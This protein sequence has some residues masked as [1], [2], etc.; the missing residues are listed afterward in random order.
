MPRQLLQAP[1]WGR[2]CEVV[3][4]VDHAKCFRD[5]PF[6]PYCQLTNPTPPPTAVQTGNRLA[7]SSRI[8]ELPEGSLENPAIISDDDS[9]RQ[10]PIPASMGI[11]TRFQGT[12][13]P[14]TIAG[15]ARDNQ[16]VKDN[17]KQLIQGPVR[18][19]GSAPIS[20]QQQPPSYARRNNF[21]VAVQRIV[22]RYLIK[23]LDLDG[24][25]DFEWRKAG[26]N[27]IA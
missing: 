8:V 9:P 25:K 10:M 24:I 23:E 6:C 16:I 22:G 26:T 15:R 20:I 2:M 21:K 14:R 1:Y 18:N 12:Q 17:R 27:L 7:S 13:W 11:G 19:A 4:E 5:E 3:H